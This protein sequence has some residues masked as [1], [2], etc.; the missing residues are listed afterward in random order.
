MSMA[1]D[2]SDGVV[3]LFGGENTTHSLFESDTWEFY[4]GTWYNVSFG[5]AAFPSG[6]AGSPMTY[7]G[8]DGY[9]LL[10]G[11]YSGST[12]NADTWSFVGGSWALEHPATSPGAGAQGVM[13]YDAT[14]STVVY[15]PGYF[16]SEPAWLY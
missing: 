1:Y 4:G 2:A 7:D 16:G 6:R 10:F 11:G 3:V 13:A 15:L 9:L 12:Y 8:W 14:D 5:M